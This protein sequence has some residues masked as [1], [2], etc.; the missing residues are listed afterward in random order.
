MRQ[1][2]QARGH[3][4]QAAQRVCHALCAVDANAA[5]PEQVPHLRQRIREVSCC[6]THAAT[7]CS[8]QT[9]T[10]QTSHGRQDPHYPHAERQIKVQH[11]GHS[12]P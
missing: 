11:R 5:L 10:R 1:R 3:A 9:L 2:A 12:M 6:G 4:G 8:W 7:V